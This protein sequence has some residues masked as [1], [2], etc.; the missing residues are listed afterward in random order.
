MTFL[1]VAGLAIGMSASLLILLWVQ[2]ELSYDKFNKKAENIYRVE[3]DQ[4]YSGERYHVTVTP[5]PSGPVWKEK[6]PEIVEQARINRLPRILFRNED[7]VFFESSIVASDSGLF[8]MFTL[9]LLRGDPATALTAPYSIVLSEKLADKYFGD[10]NPLGKTVTLENRYQFMVTGVMK[11]IPENSIFTFEGVIPFSFL[12]EIGAVSNS[13]GS[14]SIF[15]YVEFE[16]GSDLESVGKKLTDVVL[17]YHPTTTTKFSV[18]PFLDIHM[19]SQFGFTETR[20]PVIMIYIFSLIA[21]FV[22][23]IACIN[24][25]NLSTAKASSR[26]KEIGIR[27]VV[28][29]DRKT[30]IVQFMSESLILVALSM[31]L[32]LMLVGLSLQLFNNVSGKEFVL[33]DLLNGKFIIS[34]ITIG[35]LAGF[36]SGLYPAFYL[37]AVQP[38]TTL[39][40]EG[41][42]GKGNGTLRRV[43]VVVQFSLSV[44]IAV[45]AVFMFMQLRFLQDKDLGFDKENLIAIT[46]S[47]EMKGKY[48]SLKRELSKETLI[49]G[50]TAGLHNP[51][52]M[53]SNSGGADWDGKDPDKHVLIGTNGVDYDY[54]ETMKMELVSGRDF[55]R[56]FTADIARDT[57]GN[58]MVNEEVVRLMD[59]GDPVGKNFRFMGL[60][61]T[62]IGVLKNFHFKGAD[63]EI[64]PMAFALADTSFLRTILVRLTPGKTKESLASVEKTWNEIIPEFPLQYTFIDQDY[65]NLFRTEMRLADLLKYFTLLALII[66]SLGLYG[67]SSYSTE[68]RTNEIGIRKVMGADSLI[69][70]RTMARE[71]LVL[72]MISLL[73]ALPA[74]WVIVHKLLQQFTYRI[75]L[76]IIVFAGIAAGTIIIAM[77]TVGYQAFKASRINPAEA[78]KIE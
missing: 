76:D 67:L 77:L 6:I 42:A 4:F 50:V 59:I 32:A 44:I 7:K 12:R 11:E 53:G 62:I 52:M 64:E 58:F 54:L 14:N 31:I 19:H 5:Q 49:Q 9:P 26:S 66:A 72:V 16:E 63:Q 39:K 46:M 33:A 21:V 70:I 71:F 40:G 65:G 60:R 37:S 56:E 36:L 57:A 3:E 15:T 34:Y 61:G 74:G 73:I 35:I 30:M 25:I 17:E 20:G 47:E 48:Y 2:D 51:V 45:S 1:N 78:L 43:L 8:N 23:L 75:D 55:S 27:K 68:R 38:V 28:G 18:F 24:F 41:F 13:W 69:V 10:T 22:L 29:A